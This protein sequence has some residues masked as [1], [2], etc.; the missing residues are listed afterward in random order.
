MIKQKVPDVLYF[1]L[2]I[3]YFY[4]QQYHGPLVCQG[5]RCCFGR[6]CNGPSLSRLYARLGVCLWMG[7]VT[8]F[9]VMFLS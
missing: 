2:A 8:A 7:W 5:I 3:W 6:G 1:H 4:L 9:E